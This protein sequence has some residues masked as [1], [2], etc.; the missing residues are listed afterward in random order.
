L[1]L[2]YP[3][4]GKPIRGRGS[5]GVKV[6]HS[7][8]EMVSHAAALFAE[9]PRIMVEE[10][11]AGEEGTVTVLPV[12]DSTARDGEES[13]KKKKKYTALPVVLRTNHHAGIAPYNGTVAV[14]TNSRAITAAEAA[15]DPAYAL[16]QR[17]CEKAAELLQPTGVIRIDVRRRACTRVAPV[18]GGAVRQSQAEA[19][20]EVA[21]AAAAAEAVD[22]FCLFDLNVKPVSFFSP[23][24]VTH[25]PR[26]K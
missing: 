2:P 25:H 17:E 1:S 18:N 8:E 3:V 14:S 20:E 19:D 5:H 21:A 9:S 26:D 23:L 10:Y 13:A 11:L 12:P 4:V 16:V 22:K 6:C 7:V 15:L 24:L